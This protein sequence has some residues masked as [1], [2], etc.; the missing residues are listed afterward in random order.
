[1][2]NTETVTR[3]VVLWDQLLSI[4]MTTV[5]SSQGNNNRTKQKRPRLIPPN[6]SPYTGNGITIYL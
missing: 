4:Y 5:S 2:A 3:L 6:L 1:M